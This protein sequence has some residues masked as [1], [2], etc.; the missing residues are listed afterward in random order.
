MLSADS[1]AVFGE[2]VETLSGGKVWLTGFCAFQ[3]GQLSRDCRAQVHVFRALEKHGLMGRVSGLFNSSDT[4]SDS[5]SDTP[6]NRVLDR[7]QDKDKGK[8]EDK[9]T[10]RE[11]SKT[12]S[13]AQPEL[14]ILTVLPPAS[15][16]AVEPA[17]DA[18]KAEKRA[19]LTTLA[20][21][22]GAIMRR[23][24]DTRWS[25]KEKQAP[26]GLYP[27]PADDL[28]L[29]E[30]YYR[31]PIPA[32]RDYRHRDLAT[33]LHNWPGELDRA[34]KFAAPAEVRA[35]GSHPAFTLFNK[36][37]SNLIFGHFHRAGSHTFRDFAGKTYG[38]WA[39][40]CLCDLRPTYAAY[41]Q[42]THG[43]A[44]IEYSKSG[45]FSVE[46][47]PILKTGRTAECMWRGKTFRA[48]AT[49]PNER[50]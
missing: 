5:L 23:R 37:K 21:R 33:L 16:P 6:S 14:G 29:V 42:W 15:A 27:I 41:N 22:V 25:E 2:R 4:L 40:G 46:Q 13:P 3:Y 10:E 11:E 20:V 43:F 9:R 38:A 39:A 48:T 12:P 36:L 50:H 24:P 49:G 31:A 8:E 35:G 17:P 26:A 7:D 47:V 32:E 18:A 1:L 19:A 28:A 45:R 44:L 34:R 30:A